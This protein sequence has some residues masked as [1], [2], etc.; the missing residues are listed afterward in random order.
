MSS[1]ERGLQNIGLVLAAQ[2]AGALNISLKEL[3][4]Q[5]KL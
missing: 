5:A 2:I 4:G 1:I 3:I